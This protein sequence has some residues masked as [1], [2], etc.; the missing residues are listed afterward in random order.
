MQ[1]YL[2]KNW[3]K[4]VI[5]LALAYVVT[6]KSFHFNVHF[7]ESVNQRNE[8]ASKQPRPKAAK[9]GYT[10]R[11]T[12]PRQEESVFS[13][14]PLNTAGQER[15]L[16]ADSRTCEEFV[17]RFAKVAVNEKHKF[18]IPASVILANALWFGQAGQSSAASKANN[19]F[20]LA[21]TSDWQGPTFS[22]NGQ[23]LRQYQTPWMSFRDHSY[24]LTTGKYT[25]MRQV[26][27]NDIDAWLAGLKDLGFYQSKDEM[28][29]V[30]L[31]IEQFELR[32]WDNH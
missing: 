8:P 13:I 12:T 10:S 5:L 18:G 2:Q 20:K 24:Y 28:N 6:K 14:D 31:L 4:V 17:K 21:C 3:L 27:V 9:E 1:Q 29:K 22:T 16:D 7:N 11:E 23:C 32:A 15:V 30:K 25:P 19:I 26:N